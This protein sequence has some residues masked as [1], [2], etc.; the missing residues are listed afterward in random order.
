MA[1]APKYG[2]KGMID[3]SLRVNVKFNTCKHNEMIMPLEFKT[4]KATNGQTAME[5]NAQV[6]LYTLLMSERS[7]AGNYCSKI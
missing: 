2:L 1:W 7:D 4:G 6:M 3:A 5:H